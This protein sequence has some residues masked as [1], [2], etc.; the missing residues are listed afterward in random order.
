MHS[1]A[2]GAVATLSLVLVLFTDALGINPQALRQHLGV[3]AVLLGPGTLVT[4]GIIGLA[5]ALLLGVGPA[6]AAVLGARPR[7]NRSGHDARPDPPTR[8]PAGEPEQ[9]SGSRA[10]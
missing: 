8:S 4:A 3:A 1:S 10:A 5:A 6:Q 9:P 2:L 7:L